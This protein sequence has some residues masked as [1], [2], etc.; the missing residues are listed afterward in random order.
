VST[1][2]S[3]V[4]ILAA[5]RMGTVLALPPPVPGATSRYVIISEGAT[6]AIDWPLKV[7]VNSPSIMT[8]ARS[9]AGVMSIADRSGEVLTMGMGRSVL[10]KVKSSWI[11]AAR[12]VS[13]STTVPC[14]PSNTSMAPLL[15]TKVALVAGTSSVVEIFARSSSILVLSNAPSSGMSSPLK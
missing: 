9:R 13:V 6:V 5:E 14:L 3:K 10:W 8:F 15:T 2:S 1:V 7:I 11:R 4:I 12:S